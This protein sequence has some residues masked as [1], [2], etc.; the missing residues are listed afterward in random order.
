M[1]AMD[2]GGDR[3]R[4]R[5]GANSAVAVSTTTAAG[6]AVGSEAHTAAVAPPIKC[7]G[8]NHKKCT[9][10]Q[11]AYALVN[12]RCWGCSHDCAHRRMPGYRELDRWDDWRQI[13]ESEDVTDAAAAQKNGAAEGGKTK[14]IT[15][16]WQHVESREIRQTHPK[17]T[18][19]SQSTAAAPSTAATFTADGCAGV[20]SGNADDGAFATDAPTGGGAA[21]RGAPVDRG[22]GHGLGRGRGRGRGRGLGRGRGGKRMDEAGNEAEVE[23]EKKKRRKGKQKY[24]PVSR[25]NFTTPDPKLDGRGGGGGGAAAARGSP[26]RD[27]DAIRARSSR[28]THVCAKSDGGCGE[29]S[30]ECACGLN[31]NQDDGRGY[32]GN[33]GVTHGEIECEST[34][35]DG[36]DDSGAAAAADGEV[37]GAGVAVPKPSA[38]QAKAAAATEAIRIVDGA[39]QSKN[40]VVFSVDF[41]TSGSGAKGYPFQFSCVVWNPFEDDLSEPKLKGKVI[42]EFNEYCTVPDDAEWNSVGAVAS[43]GF[44]SRTDA[45]L[46]G[47]PSLH[48]VFKRFLDFQ[49][50]FLSDDKVGMYVAWN[51]AACEATHQHR[52][53]DDLFKGDAGIVWPEKMTLFW[54]PRLTCQKDGCSLN[55]NKSGATRNAD[56]D[57]GYSCQATYC[58]AMSTT[59]HIVEG[60]HGSHDSLIDSKA[61]LSVLRVKRHL[62]YVFN[63]ED[64]TDDVPTKKMVDNTIWK[65]MNQKTNAVTLMTYVVR[66]KQEKLAL[67]VAELCRPVPPGWTERDTGKDGDW[68]HSDLEVDDPD[69]RGPPAG[70][71]GDAMTVGNFRELHR[72]L[73]PDSFY[74][75]IVRN[76][77][78]YGN[79]EWVRDRHGQDDGQGDGWAD[80]ND[81]GGEGG[82]SE[83]EDANEDDAGP[84]DEDDEDDSTKSPNCR[85]HWVRCDRTADGARHRYADKKRAWVTPTVGMLKVYHAILIFAKARGVRKMS[86]LWTDQ[87]GIG[88]PWIRNSMTRDS[89]LQVRFKNNAHTI[90]GERM[91]VS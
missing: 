63:K 51:G 75:T 80:I 10:T 73:F 85:K 78:E 42:G 68:D 14:K 55:L 52:L 26:K 59:D 44:Y 22:R 86:D 6:G 21:P 27:A 45:R 29:P 23:R 69:Y 25:N 57:E 79:G 11:E 15:V 66:G 2:A 50:S 49:N 12:G 40:L 53:I 71:K 91:N 17:D 1:S 82:E 19:K 74:Q 46:K 31:K 64:G 56:R 84:A 34:D 48:V 16:Y 20:G 30:S 32:G 5:T 37:S 7:R 77:E 70:P 39:I 28:Q 43:H 61:Q 65:Q 4:P 58:R 13:E 67:Q 81:S 76:T 41:E 83:G 38:T 87:Y 88:C 24:V 18:V 47:K 9:Y 89:F 3:K 8:T 72:L 60:L 35:D 54:D 33:K 62:N 90:R 36:D